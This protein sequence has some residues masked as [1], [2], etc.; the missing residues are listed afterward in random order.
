[1]LYLRTIQSSNKVLFECSLKKN[2]LDR[3]MTEMTIKDDIEPKPINKVAIIGAG[4]MGG[5]IAMCFANANIS[6]VLVDANKESLDR[7]LSKISDNYGKQVKRERISTEQKQAAMALIV[8]ELSINAVYDSDLIIE[9][10]FEDMDLKKNIFRAMDKHAKQGAILATNTST[11]DINEISAVTYRPQNVIGLHFFSPANV[12]PLLEVVRTDTTSRQVIATSMSVAKRIRKTPILAKICYGFIGNRMMEG[13]A[14]E[15]E[16]MALEGASPNKIDTALKD[17]G[18]A[19]GILTVFDMAGIDVGVNVRKANAD[20][21]PEDPNYYQASQALYDAG[22]LGQKNGKGYY[23]YKPR[24]R[25]PYDDEEALLIIKQRAKALGVPQRNH[26]TEEVIERC[27]FPLLNEALKILDEGIAQKASDI[28]TVWTLGYGFPKNKGGPLH[29]AEN[30]LGLKKLYQGIIKY[31]DK[32]GPM[33][34]RPARLLQQLVSDGLSI[35][36]WQANNQK[37]L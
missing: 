23:F 32:F 31:Q 27:I 9:A 35:T 16:L 26:T 30:I 29:Y 14:R 4:T 7:G 34:W 21:L 3:E 28:D 2:E 12:M 37:R 25:Q 1:M 10:V 5:G 33:H 18:M 20:K 36:Q 22:R 19:M 11:F 17:F 8:G 24:D 13:Y 6:V 15:A